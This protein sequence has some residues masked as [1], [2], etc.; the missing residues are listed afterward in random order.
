MS[1]INKEIIKIK[2]GDNKKQIFNKY[3]IIYVMV[4]FEEKN[5]YYKN[6]KK[7]VNILYSLLLS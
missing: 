5:L 2:S 3:V 1:G 6:N 7:A 4:I